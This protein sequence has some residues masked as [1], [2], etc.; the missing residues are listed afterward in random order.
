MVEG[1]GDGG[2]GASATNVI[3]GQNENKEGSNN[4][5]GTTIDLTSDNEKPETE[6][7]EVSSTKKPPRGGVKGASTPA[8]S[9]GVKRAKAAR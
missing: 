6:P 1:E 7:T 2:D 9:S 5:C 4:E 3:D 8:T